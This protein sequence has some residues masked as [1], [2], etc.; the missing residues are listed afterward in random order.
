[1]VI[2][3]QNPI[4]RRGQQQQP[5]GKFEQPM[6]RKKI[7]RRLAMENCTMQSV[8]KRKKEQD[9]PSGHGKRRRAAEK[10]ARSTMMAQESAV[11]RRSEGNGVRRIHVAV[12]AQHGRR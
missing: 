4:V 10:S 2:R 8:A 5:A 6:I 1:M 12:V 9:T 3:L 11:G 7:V